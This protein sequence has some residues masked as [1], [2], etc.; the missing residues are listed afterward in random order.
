[1]NMFDI[2]NINYLGGYFVI[3]CLIE[4]FL[5]GWDKFVYLYIVYWSIRM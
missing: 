5:V 1:M 4:V 2:V 3:D